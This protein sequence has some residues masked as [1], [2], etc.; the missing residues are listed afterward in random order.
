MSTVTATNVRVAN[1]QSST[2]T[3]AFTIDSSGR[4]RNNNFPYFFATRY[5]SSDISIAIN[6][7]IPFPDI[8]H[9]RGNVY[10]GTVFTAPI[11]GVYMFHI[12]T[13]TPS[14]TDQLDLRWYR[15]GAVDT[16]L[17]AGYAGNWTGHKP[18]ISFLLTELQANDTIT[19]YTISNPGVICCNV[20]NSFCGYLVG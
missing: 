8:K 13:L 20:H 3:T 5:I 10:N 18:M 16:S 6:N 11:A 14:T 12:K 1:I 7:I 19:P 15:N 4:V 9:N 17:G 2:G